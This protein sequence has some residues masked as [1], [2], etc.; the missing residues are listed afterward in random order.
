[1][2]AL[3]AQLAARLPAGVLRLGR[4]VTGLRGRT[5]LTEDGALDGP[6]GRWWPPTR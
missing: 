6:R 3:P 4:R 1:M 2:G 5:V